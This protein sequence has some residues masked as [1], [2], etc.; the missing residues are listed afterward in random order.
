MIESRLLDLKNQCFAFLQN[1]LEINVTNRSF[2][3]SKIDE[4][5][6][7]FMTLTLFASSFMESEK[8]GVIAL[9]V[10]CLTFVKLCTKKNSKISDLADQQFLLDCLC[11]DHESYVRLVW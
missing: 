1:K 7:F 9:V 2:I 8:L 5:I 4:I 10:I 11:G 6:L 3:L